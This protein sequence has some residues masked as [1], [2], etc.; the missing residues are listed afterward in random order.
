MASLG[1]AARPAEE[2]S[3]GFG[4]DQSRAVSVWVV[5]E[6]ERAILQ[7]RPFSP[8]MWP[9]ARKLCA[10]RRAAIAKPAFQ[11]HKAS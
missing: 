4:T 10:D 8:P 6:M 11:P 1:S 9:H 3:S 5:F 7:D 2:E